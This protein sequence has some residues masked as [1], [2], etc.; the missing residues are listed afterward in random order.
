MSR[1]DALARRATDPRSR[2][3]FM[4]SRHLPRMS[5]ANH[6]P[7]LRAKPTYF[8]ICLQHTLVQFVL[9]PLPQMTRLS[10]RVPTQLAAVAALYICG[11]SLS[12]LN[13]QPDEPC[14]S[15]DENVQ[16]SGGDQNAPNSKPPTDEG[17]GGRA[18]TSKPG[19]QIKAQGG[20]TAKATTSIPNTGSGRGGATASDTEASG[21][22][23][24]ASLGGASGFGTP[25][26]GGQAQQTYPQSSGGT[27]AKATSTTKASSTPTG[28]TSSSGTR[29]DAGGSANQ[30]GAAPVAGSTARG[31]RSGTG[32]HT[33][34]SALAGAAGVAKA[35]RR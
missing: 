3:R 29:P 4:H 12:C 24:R 15:D 9:S 11:C 17:T 22:G 10:Y 2:D 25:S 30:A 20:A 7:R 35:I 31:G 8:G 14:N 34:T 18:N 13:P 33:S 28:G 32:G 16:S 26:S 23:G 19:T 6:V 27:T 5:C 21:D 1:S